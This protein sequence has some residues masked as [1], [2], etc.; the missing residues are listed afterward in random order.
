MQRHNGL[1]PPSKFLPWMAEADGQLH[2][3]LRIVPVVLLYHTRHRQVS[4]ENVLSFPESSW[5]QILLGEVQACLT[6][7]PYD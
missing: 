6:L 1:A 4:S 2:L 5:K 3:Q 7:T